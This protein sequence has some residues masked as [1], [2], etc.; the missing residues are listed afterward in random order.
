MDVAEWLRG[1]GLGQY[2]PAFADNGVDWQVLPKLTAD[3]LKEI[4][5]A[6][7]GHRR[8]LLDAIAA[9]SDTPTAS[10]ATPS[11]MPATA[12]RRQLTVMFCDLVGSTALAGRLDP[13]DLRDVIGAYHAVV[14]DEVGRF[15]GYVAKYM[16][17]GVLV[18][19]G[20]PQAQEDD[21]ER[22]VRAGLALIERVPTLDTTAR[23]QTRIGIATGLVVVGD[24][25]GEGA[26][27]ERGVVGGT[28]NLA[29][30][31]QA[32]AEPNNLLIGESTHRLIGDLFECRDLGA[33]ELRGIAEPMPAWQVLRPSVV[34]SRFEALHATGLSPLVGRE[35]ELE[36]LVRRWRRAAAGEGQVVL[37][38]GEPGIGKSRLSAALQERLRDEPHIRLRYFCSP[39][40]RDSALYP[41]IAQL[42]H[43]VAFDHDDPPPARLEKLEAVLAESGDSS[44]KTAGMLADLLG[45]PAEGRYPPLPQDPQRRRELTLA[46]LLGQLEG[47]ARRLPILL[48]FDDAHWADS[49]SLELLDRAVDRLEHLPVMMIM[50]FRPDFAPPWVGQANVTTLALS[51]LAG[52]EAAALADSV[53]GGKPLP[54]EILDRI[55]EHTDGIPLFV[56][57]LTKSLLESGLLR[58]GAEGY[59][60]AGPLPPLAIP[61]SL[62]DSLMARLDRLAP[63]KEVAQIGA[64][65]GREFSYELLAA[66]A[67]RGDGELRSALDQL[68]EA[69]LVFR[70]GAAPRDSFIF[71]HALVQDA[72]YS[73]LL[74]AQRQELHARIAKALEEQFPD[75]AENQPEVLARHYTEASLLSDA[76][77]KW[78]AAAQRALTRGAQHEA[79]GHFREAVTLIG[80][81]PQGNHRRTRE[82]ELLLAFG[83][84]LWG[85]VGL[86]Q[87]TPAYVRAAEL[88][89]QMR[90]ADAFARAAS[91]IFGGGAEAVGGRNSFL[92]LGEEAL[93]L[94]EQSGSEVALAAATRIVGTGYYLRGQLREA[95]LHLRKGVELFRRRGGKS[96]DGFSTDPVI[97]SPA[98]LSLPLWALGR[99]DEAA[100]LANESRQALGPGSDTNS[101][102]YTLGLIAR[103]HILRREP[104]MA[105]GCTAEMR[106]LAEERGAP[107]W[108][109]TAELIDGVTLVQIGQTGDGLLKL[110]AASRLREAGIGHLHESLLRIAE[111]AGY[112]ALDRLEECAGCLAAA[113]QKMEETNLRF[114]EAELYR[115]NAAL[116][117]RRG[118]VSEA[119]DRYLKSIAVARSQAAK[120][121]ELRSTMDL[122]RLMGE[123]S[124]R[125]EARELL[126]PVYGWFTEG[127]ETADLKEAKALLDELQ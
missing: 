125:A 118:K 124:R 11:A 123:Q 121:W 36:L 34:E 126:A 2:T 17:D 54:A 72:A 41:F 70:R 49:T 18:Y 116:L 78:E 24:L 61:S 4:G 119:Q 89:R 114:F 68:T 79:V 46:A 86:H 35:D 76:V 96:V 110:E 66:I 94:A 101:F 12:E 45:I 40:H 20:Y 111:A 14:A 63:V 115:V 91:G 58:E 33:V 53:A 84:A 16:G 60:L 109:K 75:A 106:R 30:R 25:I 92:S 59:V 71:K 44:G 8:L 62:R 108:H 83:Q 29:A 43:A 51:R 19:F 15:D 93:T 105:M 81:L 10:V 87:A 113:W 97:T 65:I 56:E 112:L 117:S 122:A 47:L 57:E 27:Q 7:V 52:R 74:R 48:L 120:S 37:L 104:D 64:A 23:L 6:A 95:E 39:H 50:T 69:G 90:D 77:E 85:S 98:N 80:D 3:D 42:E 100:A 5:V 22:A 38:S 32:M 13:E 28:P 88:A 107:I 1:L 82:L 9:L 103:L 73:T 127:F 55:V 26:A 102:A 67:R 21:A 99:P 31:L